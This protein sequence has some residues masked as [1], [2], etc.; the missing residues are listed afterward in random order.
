MTQPTC[1]AIQMSSFFIRTHPG[2]EDRDPEKLATGGISTGR[3]RGG[4]HEGRGRAI[5]APRY[6]SARSPFG[7]AI[8]IRRPPITSGSLDAVA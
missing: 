6:Q 2:A 3:F 4:R 8:R 5:A 1:L 7:T